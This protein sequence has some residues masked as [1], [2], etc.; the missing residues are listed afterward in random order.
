MAQS[1]G[2]VEITAPAVQGNG[3]VLRRGVSVSATFT[4]PTSAGNAILFPFYDH[5]AAMIYVSGSCAITWYVADSG[6]ATVKAA[7]DD[8]STPVA[9]TQSPGAEGY[10]AVPA[11]LFGAPFIAPVIASG[12]VT[13]KLIFKK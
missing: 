2:T 12:T 1:A 10:Y 7:Y 11:K 9:I 6:T 4:L 3:N 8:A 13:A 5:S